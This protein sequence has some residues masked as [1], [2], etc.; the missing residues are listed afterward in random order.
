MLLLLL[1][2]GWPPD[3]ACFCSGSAGFGQGELQFSA[4]VGAYS[5]VQVFSSGPISVLKP[6]ALRQP[7]ALWGR[8]SLL[9]KRKA[10]SE[11]C[12]GQ[13]LSCGTRTDP[14]FLMMPV[15]SRQL[16]ACLHSSLRHCSLHKEMNLFSQE[17]SG[18]EV[19]PLF[20]SKAPLSK[21]RWVVGQ[22][23]PLCLRPLGLTWWLRRH[24]AESHP[25]SKSSSPSVQQPPSRALITS[26]KHPPCSGHSK[27]WQGRSFGL[28]HTFKFV[29]TSV[30]AP[31]TAVL[32]TA[33]LTHWK[34]QVTPKPLLSAT[35]RCICVQD[36]PADI[37]AFLSTTSKA[38]LSTSQEVQKAKEYFRLKVQHRRLA[39]RRK[40]TPN[41]HIGNS[42]PSKGSSSLAGLEVWKLTMLLHYCLNNLARSSFLWAE[43]RLS[44]R[45]LCSHG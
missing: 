27:S 14:A 11:Q 13:T 6:W 15:I 28:G 18:A 24:W 7:V 29:P 5:P 12:N 42:A 3:P 22:G 45:H 35:S 37:G 33:L 44:W 17:T 10:G 34:H 25:C 39:K 23:D 9:P 40:K 38:Q 36:Y 21:A 1:H 31:D 43:L 2:Q 26:A 19:L 32:S 4:I 16:A 30:S 8:N 20:L 41:H